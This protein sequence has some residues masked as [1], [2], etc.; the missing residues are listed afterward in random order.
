MNN[1]RS[2]HLQYGLHEY[3]VYSKSG[4]ILG[5]QYHNCQL[6]KDLD[7]GYSRLSKVVDTVIT[8]VKLLELQEAKADL[9]GL[10]AYYPELLGVG[11]GNDEIIVYLSS[12][13]M[14]PDSINS[15]SVIKVIGD[16]V[17]LNE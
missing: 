11:I 9:K 14:V 8:E 17:A 12:D 15:I 4:R 7:F 6:V 1:N 5:S 3:R 10:L 13:A 2:F 16:I